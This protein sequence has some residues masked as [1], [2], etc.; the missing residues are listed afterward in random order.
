MKNKLKAKFSA[1]C[2]V[3]FLLL[4]VFL[5][6]CTTDE[7]A[8]NIPVTEKNDVV[9]KSIS[10][11]KRLPEKSNITR[12][13]ITY[14]VFIE[15]SGSMDGYVNGITDFKN[16]I[17]NFLSDINISPNTD[18][19]NLFYINSDVV[20]IIS[21]ASDQ[22]IKRFVDELDP[23]HF[24][25]RRGNRTETELRNIIDITEPYTTD[26]SVTIIVSDF[27]FSPGKQKDA[28][29]YLI[30]EQ[31]GFKGLFA[32]K[33]R[34][35][36]TSTVMMRFHSRFNGI[37]YD[38]LNNP[39]FILDETERPFYAMLIGPD[40]SV[41]KTMDIILRD[42]GK[43]KQRG[44]E[45]MCYFFN[46]S[47]THVQIPSKLTHKNRIGD[48][49]IDMPPTKM[50]ILN[51]DND[52][53]SRIPGTKFRFSF[54]VDFKHM[55]RPDNYL[56]SEKN[57][58]VY[59]SY[60]S[61]KVEPLPENNDPGLKGYTHLITVSTN[62]LKNP[63]DS[64]SIVLKNHIADW[65]PNCSSD[66]DRFINKDTTQMRRT[67]GLKYLMGGIDDAYKIINPEN[68]KLFSVSIK[69]S[70]ASSGSGIIWWVIGALILT[71]IGVF[72]FKIK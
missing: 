37:Y 33:I 53:D 55:V 54:V 1:V 27:I 23:K 7:Q 6:S 9:P 56:L 59:P 30:E 4:T 46:H 24:K 67:Y 5:S 8:T 48:F 21:D 34:N 49:E 52:N 18:S 29:N 69:V 47:K 39:L 65:I 71:V 25:E 20:R 17:Y 26:K 32:Q 19:I 14:N 11:E 35:Y 64:I 68:D 66:D 58:V 28:S 2:C 16:S 38:K 41:Q 22:Q 10:N 45:E 70:K 40:P 43:Y 3:L 15:N 62:E 60:Y 51:A 72:V 57:Y 63:N 50:N 36:N 61:I 42:T 44:F 12:N 31:I 13:K